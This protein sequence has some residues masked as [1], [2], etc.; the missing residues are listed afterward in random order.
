MSPISQ[1]FSESFDEFDSLDGGLD[2]GD[3]FAVVDPCVPYEPLLT[4]FFDGEAT[5]EEERAMRA[6]LDYCARCGAMWQQ[7]QSTRSLLQSAPLPSIPSGLLARILMA[8]RLSARRR[9]PHGV[10]PREARWEAQD[11]HVLSSHRMAQMPHLAELSDVAPTSRP[12][13]FP[14]MESQPVPPVPPH[15]RDQILRLTVG[16]AAE[17]RTA[18]TRAAEARRATTRQQSS[19]AATV[20]A[21][22]RRAMHRTA[23]MATP[24]IAIWL[25]VIMQYPGS[26]ISSALPVGSQPSAKTSA[27]PLQ[28]ATVAH[29]SLH[30]ARISQSVSPSVA[31]SPAASK[32]SQV[33]QPVV[34]N[35]APL[36]AVRA[37]AASLLASVAHAPQRMLPK[38]V[39]APRLSA[40][41][42]VI[43]VV[44]ASKNASANGDK[45]SVR[46]TLQPVAPLPTPASLPRATPTRLAV[47]PR[48][49]IPVHI[50]SPPAAALQHARGVSPQPVRLAALSHTAATVKT[51]VRRESPGVVHNAPARPAAAQQAEARRE[52]ATGDD[53][54]APEEVWD[55]IDDPAGDH[56]EE[57]RQIVNDY[58]SSLLEEDQEADLSDVV[59]DS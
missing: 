57:V 52:I 43:N 26:L 41:R 51:R 4:A 42:A 47:A 50:P 54:V 40:P 6:H 5:A 10:A 58:R 16:A 53:A 59:A 30:P 17:A 14:G 28:P 9:K 8:C 49:S 31:S 39:A 12:M 48:T 45:E 27:K 2:G 25:M 33:E 23:M 13:P 24:A 46:S 7:W 44:D 20:A 56:P 22:G 36:N 19:S 37:T 21:W 55:E 1:M 18:E 34:A 35:M 38:S 3:A 32:S 11:M 29:S 15:L